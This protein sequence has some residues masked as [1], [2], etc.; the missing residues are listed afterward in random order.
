VFGKPR[1]M[2]KVRD[3]L[4]SRHYSYRTEQQYTGWIRR[5][6]LFHGRKH[7]REL[8]PG[9]ITAFLSHLVR[10]R[11]VASATQAQ[12]LAALLFL[13]RQVLDVPLPWIGNIPRARR[14]K[15]LP[16][17]LTRSEVR[18]VLAEL[19]GD[20]WLAVSLLYGSGLRLM[21]LLR[22]RVKDLDLDRRELIVRGGKGNKDR[23]SV[24]P[25]ALVEPLQRHLARVGDAHTEAVA[26]GFGGV[27]LPPGLER[28]YPRAH[29]EVGWQYVFPAA[30][31][32]CDPRSG[33]WRRHHLLEYTIQRQVKEALR[34]ARIL[35]PA[36]P[37]TFR[38]SFATHLLESGTDIRTVQELLGHAS[39]K[40]TQIYTHAVTS[41]DTPVRSP[42]DDSD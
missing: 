26:R 35:K 29:L 21:E 1:L 12:A 37:H 27:E 40:T 2:D 11:N 15:R 17:V 24:I 14:P 8:G 22:L 16:V 36:S 42:L 3:A 19:R 18:R 6:I 33:I 38:H 7:P 9:D 31:P 13:Y 23:V 20:Y 39:V 30:R 4:R 25:L 10:D 5:Y 34:R 32:S 28:K 41:G